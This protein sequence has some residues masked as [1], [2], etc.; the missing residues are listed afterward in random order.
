MTITAAYVRNP[1][2]STSTVF[3][4]ELIA[5][6]ETA[7]MTVSGYTRVSQAYDLTR[8]IVATILFP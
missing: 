4:I 5:A 7:T 6:C 2:M 1:A 8:P 3:T